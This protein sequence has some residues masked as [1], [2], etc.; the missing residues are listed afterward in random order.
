M[1]KCEK[2]GGREPER[3]RHEF[4]PEKHNNEKDSFKNKNDTNRRDK[5]EIPCERPWDDEIY[6]Y[7]VLVDWQSSRVCQPY[8]VY[9]MSNTFGF[10]IIYINTLF[11]TCAGYG[12]YMMFDQLQK[13]E[14]EHGQAPLVRFR[15]YE[16]KEKDT[17][18]KVEGDYRL[19]VADDE[20]FLH[21]SP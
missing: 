21:T 19:C 4:P 3:K 7:I 11:C 15:L 18:K 12:S 14:K 2:K 20:E 9:V 5:K 10:Y 8:S 6:I 1:E 17:Q 13:R 16:N